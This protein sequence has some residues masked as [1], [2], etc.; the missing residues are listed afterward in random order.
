VFLNIFQ[1]VFL[2]ISQGAS[3]LQEVLADRWAAL[4]YGTSAFEA[5]LRHVIRRSI[6]FDVGADA[7]L[8]DVL[9]NKKPL[10]NLY[11]QVLSRDQGESD[12]AKSVEA[13]INAEPS[14][15]DSHPSPADRFELVRRLKAA[16][17]DGEVGSDDE[18]WSLFEDKHAIE[19]RMTQQVVESARARYGAAIESQAEHNLDIASQLEVHGYHEQALLAYAEIEREYPDTEAARA[20]TISRKNLEETLRQAST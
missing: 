17:E 15:Y 13:A 3:R 16:P 6:E 14:P 1:R 9:T 18:V 7:V 8:R 5:G 20:A 10:D 2:R 11:D 12:I 4:A 19:R